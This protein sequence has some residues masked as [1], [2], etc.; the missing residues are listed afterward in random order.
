MR[1]WPMRGSGSSSSAVASR[2]LRNT[3]DAAL[4]VFVGDAFPAGGVTL[5]ATPGLLL[6]SASALRVSRWR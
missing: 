6:A 5:E 3:S 2:G 1:G 4:R